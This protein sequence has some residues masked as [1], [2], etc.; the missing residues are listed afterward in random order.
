MDSNTHIATVGAGTLLGD[1]Q[2]RLYNA[3]GRAVAHGTCPQV[4]VGGHFTIG[5]LGPMSR[6][7][8]TALDHIVEAEVVLA[9]STIVKATNTQHEDVLFAIKGAAAGFGIVTEFKLRTHPAPTQAVQYSF[10]WNLGSTAEKAKM[11]KDWQKLIYSPNIT[12][13]FTSELVVSGAGIVVSGTFLGTQEEWHAFELEKHFPPSSTGNVITLSN[14]LGMLSNQ[15]EQLIEQVAGGIPA[16]FYAKSMSFALEDSITDE[17]VDAMFKYIDTAQKGTPAW[18]MIFD[19]EGG[20]VNDVPVN[21]TAYAHRHAIMWMQSYAIS[22]LG[23]V[24]TTTRTFLD[25]FNKVIASSRP[26][27]RYGT[28]PGYVDPY[29]TDPEI[30]YWGSNLPKLRQIKT[31]I[32]PTDVFHNPQSVRILSGRH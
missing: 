23:P 32:D 8:G 22:L 4:G 11:F 2:T 20:A 24:S 31:D 18:F 10:T 13:R 27:A 1:L 15:G 30:A 28:Y 9:N 16:S 21:A 12:R 7:W 17:G 5:G 14:S 29:L 6:E 19:L 3:G 26:A 25:G